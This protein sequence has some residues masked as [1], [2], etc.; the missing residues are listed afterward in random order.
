MHQL[1]IFMVIFFF[2]KT[3]ETVT[4]MEENDPIPGFA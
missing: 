2:F 1:N 4:C 3:A